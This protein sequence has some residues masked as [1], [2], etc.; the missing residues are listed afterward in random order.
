MEWEDGAGRC[1]LLYK[2]GT[3]SK[4]PLHSIENCI[5]YLIIN[6]NGKES[7]KN[8]CSLKSHR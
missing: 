5:H 4:V 6:H 2:E 7:F 3:H 8:T 1:E